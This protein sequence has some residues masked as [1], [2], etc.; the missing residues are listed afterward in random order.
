MHRSTKLGQD[1]YGFAVETPAGYDSVSIR[2]N[3]IILADFQSFDLAAG[4]NVGL[5]LPQDSRWFE[6]D[7]ILFPV[8][9]ESDI[10]WSGYALSKKYS[11][12]AP[13]TDVHSVWAPK[14]TNNNFLIYHQPTIPQDSALRFSD[15]ENHLLG[16][17][18]V[19]N[20]TLTYQV[21]KFGAEGVKRFGGESN[22]DPDWFKLTFEG[23]DKTGNSTGL[24]EFSP[25][26]LPV[27]Q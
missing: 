4:F 7:G 22:D 17:I 26:R 21:I 2:V 20:S 15:G 9:A 1:V 13:S 23:Y 8:A 27:S 12:V 6:V 19:C 11:Q 3:T 25:G 24:V 18:S 14:E 16:T 10:Q 5:N